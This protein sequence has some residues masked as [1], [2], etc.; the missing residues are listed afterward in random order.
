MTDVGFGGA[1]SLASYTDGWVQTTGIGIANGRVMANGS[2][3]IMLTALLGYVSGRGASRTISLT[4]AGASTGNFTRAS[5]GSASS[6]GWI[7]TGSTLTS[8]SSGTFRITGSGSFYFGRASSGGL[9]TNAS[10]FTWSGDLGGGYRYVEAPS[11]PRSLALALTGV[12]GEVQATWLAPSDNGGSSVTGYRLE[13]ADNAGMA[14]STLLQPATSGMIIDGLTPG[15]T[16]HV[17]VAAENAVTNAAGSSSVYTSIA[18]LLIPSGARVYLGG[19]N[20][21][22]GAT[23]E[24]WTGTEFVTGEPFVWTGSEFVPAE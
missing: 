4:F 6:T 19:G 13:H 21:D 20:F 7:G 14:G 15:S 11:A 23:F 8:A 3:A 10:G 24:V 18:S 17:R 22:T 5:A 9:A 2:D 1:S 12:S 16:V